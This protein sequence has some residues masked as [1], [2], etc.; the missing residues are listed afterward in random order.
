MLLIWLLP[1]GFAVLLKF[2]LAAFSFEADSIGA[3]LQRQ[4]HIFLQWRPCYYKCF[5]ESE[6]V[7]Q[8][9]NPSLYGKI[10][11]KVSNILKNENPFDYYSCCLYISSFET[12]KIEV[13]STMLFE[14]WN[15]ARMTAS[16]PV[17]PCSSPLQQSE[18]AYNRS[19]LSPPQPPL[20]LVGQNGHNLIEYCPGFHTR[21]MPQCGYE[22]WRENF[23]FTSQTPYGSP[24]ITRFY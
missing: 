10:I 13:T 14:H 24:R 23:Q 16:S 17:S 9:Y 15:S 5:D 8:R 20:A 18:P 3:T 22:P 2:L 11:L 12:L 19:S 4:K 6:V 1:C 21:S 7:V